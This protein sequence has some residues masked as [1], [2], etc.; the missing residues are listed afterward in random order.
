M[1]RL[2]LGLLLFAF[3]ILAV[4]AQ[5]APSFDVKEGDFILRDFRFRTG[6]VLPELRI[7]YRTLGAPARDAAGRVTNAVLILHG[8][9]GSGRGFLS[10]Q[11]GG[12][13][14]TPGG[15]LDAGKY[16]I[17]LP[18]GIGHGGSS[19]PSDGLRAKFPRYDYDDMVRAQY[20]L[21]S[22]GLGVNHLRLIL[23]TSMGCMHA[24]VWG[25]TYPEFMDALMPL[26]CN[27]VEIAGRNRMM[28]KMILDSIRHDPEWK[29]GDYTASFPGMKT[30]A[31]IFLLLTSSPLQM[32]K[33]FPTREAADKF[34][35][36]SVAAR[37]RTMEPSD[38]LYAFD[39]SRNYNAQPHL[40][41][42][43]AHVVAVNSADDII[44]P[45][46]LGIVEREIQRVKN[47]RFVLLPVTDETRGHGTHSLPRL[48]QRHLA[49]L[50]AAS[51]K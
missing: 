30:A 41:K 7:H 12:M 44:N 4:E 27:P 36:D 49:E 18:D 9:T 26:A 21:V 33:N 28:R 5:Q 3:G 20:A 43:R 8:T 2:W 1:R 34:L 15:L 42:I 11:F 25:Y 10:Q 31:Y 39:A 23:G 45:P 6:E 16:F 13:L 46:E 14:F 32:Q 51:Q 40:D 19:K 29:N 22:E 48:W 37:M 38:T 47:G 24:W 50:L 35:E 17:I